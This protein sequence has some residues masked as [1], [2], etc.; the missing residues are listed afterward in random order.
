MILFDIDMVYSSM[1]FSIIRISRRNYCKNGKI[2][3]Y[4]AIFENDLI[5]Y[6]LYYISLV[7]HE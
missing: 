3:L 2:L 7:M 6:H 1:F 5:S 4:F